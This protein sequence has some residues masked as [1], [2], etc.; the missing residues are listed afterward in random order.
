MRGGQTDYEDSSLDVFQ[1][2]TFTCYK[3]FADDSKGFYSVYR[4]VF[5]TVATEDIEYMDSELEFDLIPK[6]GDSKSDYEKVVGPFYAYW[7]S[8][9]TKKSY[10]WLSEH[11]INE[12]RERRIIKIIEKE[13]KKIQQKARKE[14]SDEIRN[15]VA[16]VRKRDKRVA[17]Y[18]VV[19]EEKS[20]LNK[21]KQEK[22]RIEQIQRRQRE[23][24]EQTANHSSIFNE[25]Y[26]ENLKY[27]Y[28]KFNPE[29]Y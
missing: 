4:E 25:G 23:L 19:L 28:L 6:F 26:E 5:N 24:A 7:Q 20:A 17:A 8:Y 22:N 27:V 18:R 13:N 16:F 2:F 29:N 1:F 11:N 12:H 10:A 3:G 14:R 15:L 9:C 21:L